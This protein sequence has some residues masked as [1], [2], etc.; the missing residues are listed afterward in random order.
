[1]MTQPDVVA[2]QFKSIGYV[3]ERFVNLVQKETGSSSISVNRNVRHLKQ[4]VFLH[5]E[6]SHTMISE[7]D[8]EQYLMPFDIQ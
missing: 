8:Y 2:S 1:M 3:I 7:S 4:P 5:S 6:C